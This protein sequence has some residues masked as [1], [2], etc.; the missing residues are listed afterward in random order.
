LKG[1][2]SDKRGRSKKGPPFVQLFQWVMKSD[3][4][5]ALSA[6]E[7]A[8]YPQLASRF[9][10]TNNGRLALSARTLA[11]ELHVSKDTAA[12]ALNALVASGLIECSKWSG[13]NQ[14]AERTSREY[15]LTC[16]RCDVTGQLP[17]N[18][19]DGQATGTARSGYRDRE[20]NNPDKTAV[21]VRLQGQI[22]SVS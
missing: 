14:K 13:F 3:Q 7:K 17:I 2:G 16:Y 10:G 21:T 4:W 15:R 9:N 6:I 19:F 5:L 20:E 1:R 12:K 18:S 22:G 11:E 8:A